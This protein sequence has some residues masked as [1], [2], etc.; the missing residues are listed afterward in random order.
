MMIE[1]LPTHKN[2]EITVAVLIT[3]P[4]IS[5]ECRSNEMLAHSFIKLMDKNCFY[6]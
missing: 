3:F 6:A 1:I 4:E 2:I 5:A